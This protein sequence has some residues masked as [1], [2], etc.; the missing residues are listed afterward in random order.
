MERETKR[1]R[2]AQFEL[3]TLEGRRLMSAGL[4]T[5]IKFDHVE[6]R[7][8]PVQPSIA[9]VVA[10]DPKAKGTITIVG[11]TSPG[12]KVILALL[13]GRIF[14]NTVRSNASGRFRHTFA[15]GYHPHQAPKTVSVAGKGALTVGTRGPDMN[16]SVTIYGKTFPE[17]KVTLDPKA[18]GA[19]EQTVKADDQGRFQFTFQVGFGKTRVGLIARAAPPAAS[20]LPISTTLTVI[21]HPVD[22]SPGTSGSSQTPSQGGSQLPINP[23]LLSAFDNL[24]NDFFAVNNTLL[25]DGGYYFS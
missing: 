10:A 8:L 7:H 18:D 6:H 22:P 14:E 12:A 17:A 23:G 20:M 15:V 16:G 9:A 5:G 13:D 21:R 3:E 4:G 2:R 25:P 24:S 1:Y 19:I 11:H